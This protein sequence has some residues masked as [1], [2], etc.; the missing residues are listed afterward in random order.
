M[1]ASPHLFTI[2]KGSRMIQ[3][4]RRSPKHGGWVLQEIREHFTIWRKGH[5]VCLSSIVWIEGE[6]LPPHWEWL[7]SFSYE[8][9]SVL[10]DEQIKKCLSDFEASEFEEDN[11]E[12][13]NARK[14]WL[15][16][17]QKYRKPCPCKDEIIVKEG[18]SIYSQK[19]GQS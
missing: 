8:G 17:D 7:I 19:K 13:G 2:K 1:R 12:R 3:P 9:R 4:Q 18:S 5:L 15:A 10:N 14:F 16:V 11:H 6:H